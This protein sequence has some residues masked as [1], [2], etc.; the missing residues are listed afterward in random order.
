MLTVAGLVVSGAAVGTTLYRLLGNALGPK[1]PIDLQVYMHGAAAIR[2]GGTLYGPAFATGSALHLPFTYPP[3][4]AIALVPFSY[5]APGPLSWVWDVALVLILGG[6]VAVAFRPL[7]ERAGTRLGRP[8]GPAFAIV[9]ITSLALCARPVYDNLGYAQVDIV[10]MAACI[11]ACTGRGSRPG[12]AVLVGLAAAIK[13]V[14]GIFIVYLVLTRRWRM[15]AAAVGSWAAATGL[16]FVLRPS[17]SVAYY[18]HLLW[19]PGRPGRPSS[20]LNQSAWG[21]LERLHLGSFQFF[22]IAFVVGVFAVVGLSRSVSAWRR[23]DSV[24]G[25]VLVGLVGVLA[26]PISWI[27]ETVWL[28]PA[29]GLAVGDAR[30]RA[31]LAAGVVLAAAMI[32]SLPYVGALALD[33]AQWYSQVLIDAYGLAAGMAVLVGLRS[34]V[35]AGPDLGPGDGPDLRPGGGRQVLGEIP[36][37][38]SA[39][40]PKAYAG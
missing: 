20:F 13:V 27:H 29:V 30:H 25:V 1:G 14:P 18:G 40:V 31:R 37:Q 39:S 35:F 34:S 28:V 11:F 32:A 6:C 26:S 12:R 21:I 8:F 22:A 17:D 5:V 36:K 15:A 19:K 38:R 4:A 9:V 33:P 24:A 3:F 7:C 16:G 10:L 23:G 2:T